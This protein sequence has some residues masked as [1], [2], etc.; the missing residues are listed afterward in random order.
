MKAECV[1]SKD[2]PE[3]YYAV[4]ESAD[5]CCAGCEMVDS[6][7]NVNCVAECRKDGHNVI[8]RKTVE[9]PSHIHD[10]KL[11]IHSNGGSVLLCFD[12]FYLP[13]INILNYGDI[14]AHEVAERLLACWNKH[15]HESVEAI[16][17]GSNG[18]SE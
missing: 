16:Q 6:C 4:A 18:K 13:R 8:F 12:G 10:K 9:K 1:D 14:S 15:I 17:G 5:G 7:H 11:T 2:A 3:G